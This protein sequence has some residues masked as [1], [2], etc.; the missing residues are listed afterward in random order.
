MGE[1]GKRRRERD[2]GRITMEDGRSK[3]GKKKGTR[4]RES[5]REGKLNT[6]REEEGIRRKKKK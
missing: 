4:I 3:G 5:K 2:G 6:G 1:C